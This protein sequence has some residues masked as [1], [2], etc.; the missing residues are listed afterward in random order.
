MQ[1]DS[2]IT[3]NMGEKSIDEF[4]VETPVREPASS[5]NQNNPSNMP[6]NMGGPNSV[7]SVVHE[8]SVMSNHKP[9]ISNETD[10]NG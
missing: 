2:R 3:E 4:Q 7:M 1:Q 5:S 8:D 10:S 6:D 9:F